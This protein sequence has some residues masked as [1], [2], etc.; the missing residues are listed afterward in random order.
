[1]L[2]YLTGG[3]SLTYALNQSKQSLPSLST[4]NAHRLE[5]N[6]ITSTGLEDL[7]GDAHVNIESLFSPK[8]WGRAPTTRKKGHSLCLDEIAIEERPFYLK[9]KDQVGGPCREHTSHLNLAVG[10]TLDNILLAAESVMGE[11]PTAHLA[12]EATVAAISALSR[13]GYYAKPVLISPTCKTVCTEDSVYIIE[14]LLRAWKESPY[15]E[16]MHGPIWSVASDGDSKRRAA[17]YKICMTHE[18]SKEDPLYAIL[19][20]LAGLNKFTSK[21]GVTK[22]FDFKHLFKR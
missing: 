22:D 15:G 16:A 21:N 20:P 2:P 19:A 4:I 5:F 3:G 17:L 8:S 14:A 12:K 7:E 1:M 13:D 9:Q 6:L 11:C 18:L 10:H